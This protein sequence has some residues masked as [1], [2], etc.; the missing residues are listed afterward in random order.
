MLIFFFCSE[1]LLRFPKNPS[2]MGGKVNGHPVL[3]FWQ[4]PA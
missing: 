3:L 4:H 2:L 1:N